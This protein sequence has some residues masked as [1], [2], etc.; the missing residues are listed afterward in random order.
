MLVDRCP[1]T[2]HLASAMLMQRGTALIWDLQLAAAVLSRDGNNSAST[3]TAEIANAA[4]RECHVSDKPLRTA[5]RPLRPSNRALRLPES[6]HY[7]DCENRAVVGPLVA[8]Q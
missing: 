7:P 3:A 8:A 5:S 4:E 1:V 2:E 6:T